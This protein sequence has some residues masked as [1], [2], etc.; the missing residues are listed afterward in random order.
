MRGSGL[1]VGVE[2]PDAATAGAIVNELRRRR[3]L[4]SATGLLG[5]TLK[6]RPPLVFSDDDAALFL[7]ALEAVLAQ[8]N[9]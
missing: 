5:N 9:D 4:I 3:V 1:Y 2:T 6:I 8:P 7:D